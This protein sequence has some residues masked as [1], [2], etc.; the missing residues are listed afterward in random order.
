MTV[1]SSN[2]RVKNNEVRLRMVPNDM[3]EYK[4]P[5]IHVRTESRCSGIPRQA[6]EKRIEWE[7]DDQRCE[8]FVSLCLSF[9]LLEQDKSLDTPDMGRISF[10]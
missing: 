5:L 7:N 1:S 8:R 2:E 4:L 10:Y 3:F 9:N 6:L